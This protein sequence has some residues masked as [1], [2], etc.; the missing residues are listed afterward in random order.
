MNLSEKELKQEKIYLGV[1]I[2]VIREKISKLGQEL[3]E[4]ED[5]VQEFQKFIWDSKSD[6]DPTEMKNMILANDTE[7][8]LMQNKGKYL[9]KLYRIQDNPYF[10]SL[11]FKSQDEQNKVY[12]GITHVEDE[13]NDIFEEMKV[14]SLQRKLFFFA[15]I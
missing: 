14:K 5:K 3:Y 4:R 13:E 15:E 11:T 10:G 8:M 9:Q 1:T 6:M 2:D 7:V 12:I